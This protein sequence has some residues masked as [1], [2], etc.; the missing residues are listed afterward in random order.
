[1]KTNN[2]QD[3][4][5]G[6]IIL[7]IIAVIALKYFLNFDII[8]WA[9]SPAVVSA[10]QPLLSVFIKIYQWLEYVIRN[11]VGENSKVVLPVIN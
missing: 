4:F 1:M 9:Q 6:R 11:L 2:N 10:V 3:G 8:E 7:L 5:I